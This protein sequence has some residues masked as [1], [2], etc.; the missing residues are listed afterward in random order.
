MKVYFLIWEYFRSDQNVQTRKV[1][2]AYFE[3]IQNRNIQMLKYS[4][5]E[6]SQNDK[7]KVFSPDL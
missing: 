7:L 5:G 2:L 1:K 4:E 3:K 6:S